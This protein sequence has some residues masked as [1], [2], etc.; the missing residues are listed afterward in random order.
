VK[1][2]DMFPPVP[3]MIFYKRDLRKENVP[4]QTANDAV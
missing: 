2:R 1:F 3:K 4:R